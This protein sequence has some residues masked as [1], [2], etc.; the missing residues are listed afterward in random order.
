M[1]KQIRPMAM[2]LTMCMHWQKS[3]N[4]EMKRPRREAHV[5]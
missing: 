3:D 4:K 5:A 1:W 2:D